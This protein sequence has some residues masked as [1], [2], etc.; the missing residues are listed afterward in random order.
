MKHKRKKASKFTLQKTSQIFQILGG[1]ATFIFFA[2]SLGRVSN[3]MFVSN[4]GFVYNITN[5]SFIGILY[6]SLAFVA[7]LSFIIAFI[8]YKSSKKRK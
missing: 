5:A 7:I 8:A 6:G 4:S 3:T 2:I 1:L